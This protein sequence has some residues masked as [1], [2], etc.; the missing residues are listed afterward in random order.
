M[1]G[2]SGNTV[3]VN[4]RPVAI[5]AER[6]LL[7]LIAKAGIELPTFC[8]HSDLSIYG[9]CRLCLVDIEGRG[10]VGACTTPPEPGMRILTHTEDITEIRRV[11]IELLLANHDG[12]CPTCPKS[13]DCRLQFLARQM[14]IDRVRF[15]P[16]LVRKPIDDSSDAIVRNP[17]KCVLCGDCARM[18]S[19]IQGIGAVD[20]VRRGCDVAVE[21][22]FGKQFGEVECVNCGQCT[23]VCPT[24]ALSFKPEM[25]D[26]WKTLMDRDVYTVAAIAPAVRVA[27]GEAFGLEAGAVSTGQMLAALENARLQAGVRCVVCR[28]PDYHGRGQRVHGEAGFANVSTPSDL[29]L[30]GLGQICGTFSPRADPQSFHMQISPLQMFGALLK[31]RLPSMMN[32]PK[33]KIRIISITPC[34]AKKYEAKRP[35]FSRDGTPDIDHA[36]TTVELGRMIKAAGIQFAGL[37][38]ESFDMPFGF[39]TSAGVIFGNSGGVTEA[40]LRFV[41][42]KMSGQQAGTPDFLEARGEAGIREIDIDIRGRNIRFAIVHGLKNAKTLLAKLAE[43]THVYDFVEVMACPQGCVNGGGQPVNQSHDYKSSRTKGLFS[44]GKMFHLHK[45]Q[46]NIMV[47]EC[48]QNFLGAIGGPEAIRLL[49]TNYRKR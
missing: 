14:G 34:T 38:P 47:T 21:P 19:E 45:P 18:C 10:I 26:V 35:E 3:H 31:E 7:E 39:S 44:A 9:A 49:H 23:V 15:E 22:A 12:N 13:N 28:R 29:M 1:F 43:G 6:N 30:S 24:G 8:Y 42:E 32:I 36:I 17:N 40:M 11:C 20:F 37:P 48:Y 33:E 5:G 41:V 16:V 46:D 27:I 4:G 2:F 25:D